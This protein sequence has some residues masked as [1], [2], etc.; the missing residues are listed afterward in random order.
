MDKTCFPR[1]FDL[2]ESERKQK[3]R[4]KNTRE[5]LKID[6]NKASERIQVLRQN[7]SAEG[8]KNAKCQKKESRKKRKSF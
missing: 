8:K 1:E 6:Q 5:N 2:K 3:S 7:K 4:E